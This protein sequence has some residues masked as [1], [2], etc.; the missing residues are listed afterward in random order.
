MSEAI[1]TPR[2]RRTWPQRLLLLCGVA[3]SVACF[4]AAQ[5]FWEART[6]LSELPRIRVG[7]GV[8]A[9][10][11]APGEPV[12]FLLVGVDSSEGLDPDD[13][14]RSGRDVVS[15]ANGRFL[16]DTILMMRL[17]PATGDASVMSIPRDLYVDVPGSSQWRI[18]STLL[19][20]GMDKLIETIDANLSVPVNHFVMVDFAGFS[21]LVE[22]VDGV[23][24]Y[25]P[26]PTRDLG[27]GLNVPEA[28]CWILDGPASLA[29][30]RARSI[31]EEIDGEWER[32]QAPAPDL[33]RIERQQEFMVLALEQALELGGSDLGRIQE[34]VAVGTQAVQ[35]DEELTPG[36]LLDLASAF[37]EYDTDALRVATLPVAPLFSDDGQYLGEELQAIAAD[38]ILQV[39]QGTA[40]GVRPPDV[41]MAVVG[42]DDGTVDRATT[43]LSD[44]G[45]AATADDPGNAISQTTIL[46]PRERVDEAVL[47]GRYLEGRA[48]FLADESV[49]GVV[50]AIGPDFAGVREFP[51][52]VATIEPAALDAARVPEPGR[53]VGETTTTAP[54]V[55]ADAETTTTSAATDASTTTS[56]T[57][58]TTTTDVSEGPT[59]TVVPTT[60]IVRGRP[61]ADVRCST[62]G[63]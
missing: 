4:G 41:T 47:V 17:D 22:L 37:A 60:T 44:R 8:L 53:N 18:N 33:A 32:L 19:I 45:F 6:V 34:F 42:N 55:D 36:E 35:L 46:F 51:S 26:Y 15:E 11:G 48:R 40:D 16:S 20:G 13:P 62:L 31:E 30:V 9:Q 61:P 38:E 25:F 52:A 27:S 21:S 23:P 63:G 29:Y 10:S 7:S 39:F 57:L 12:N 50:L 54:A 28:G 24:V 14:V 3:V 5:V 56:S 2:L 49:D 59:T 1:E 43:Q 58:G